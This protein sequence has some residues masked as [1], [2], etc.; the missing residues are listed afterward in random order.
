MVT[1]FYNNGDREELILDDET[2]HFSEPV[3]SGTSIATTNFNAGKHPQEI[4]G[5][6]QKY[7]GK[8]IFL[9]LTAQGFDQKRVSQTCTNV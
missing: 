7:F 4:L 9:K 2:W 5:D 1:D 3:S 6:M 8:K